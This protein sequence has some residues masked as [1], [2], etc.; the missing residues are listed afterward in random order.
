MKVTLED[1]TLDFDHWPSCLESFRQLVRMAFS[2][3]NDCVIKLRNEKPQFEL[4]DVCCDACLATLKPHSK[5]VASTIFPNQR[6]EE[7]G[8]EDEALIRK[9]GDFD[10]SLLNGTYN[11]N[12]RELLQTPFLK[13]IAAK[14]FDVADQSAFALQEEEPNPE[15]ELLK[16]TVLW[17]K[18]KETEVRSSPADLELADSIVK[19]FAGT[20]IKRVFSVMENCT[21]LHSW[22][23]K[24][25]KRRYNISSLDPTLFPH[26]H[27]NR[28]KPGFERLYLSGEQKEQILNDY[29]NGRIDIDVIRNKYCISDRRFYKWRKARKDGRVMKDFALEE[30]VSLPMKAAWQELFAEMQMTEKRRLN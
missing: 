9:R 19:D 29:E 28:T 18:P 11:D 1:T 14:L 2:L 16:M 21:H 22:T 13:C 3:P 30:V 24:E 12:A 4:V 7:A 10:L 5:I 15:D 23:R 25:L 27:G 8:K 17:P 26:C 6:A 20:Y